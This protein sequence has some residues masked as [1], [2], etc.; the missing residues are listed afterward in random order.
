[1]SFESLFALRYLRAKKAD[2]FISIITWLSLVGIMLGVAT[3]IIVM[4]VMNGFR[5]EMMA[6]IMGLNGH[7]IVYPRPGE[8]NI[9]NYATISEQIKA[10]L[11]S[12]LPFAPIPVIDEQVMISANGASAGIVLRG[13]APYDMENLAPLANGIVESSKISEIR[14]VILG[15]T[16]ANR[17]NVMMGDEVSITSANG[18]QTAFGTVPRIKAFDVGATFKSGMSIYD[19]TF[20][21]IDFETAADF[22]DMAGA[23]NIE[24]FINSP[25]DAPRAAAKLRKA[26]PGYRIYT[27]QDQNSS[28]VS[29]LNVERNVMFIILTLIIIVASF[30]IISSLVMLV[31]DK[32]RDIAVLRTL[33]AT[34][35]SITRIFIISGGIIG[36]GGTILGL[37]LGLLISFNIEWVRQLFQVLTGTPLFPEEVYFLSEMPSKVQFSEVFAVA[38]MSLLISFIATIYP[39]R[40]AAKVAPAKVLRYE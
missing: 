8:T 10:T 11:K 12:D 32:S 9:K 1:M 39:A 15:I 25:D 18:N 2:G 6:K 38:A 22:L 3:L 13:I 40:K 24:I 19:T 36:F 30:N 28:F 14:G 27:W 16:L 5:E 17:L 21:F 31:S 29:A 4:S 26:L 34:K 20:G 33:G 35:K 23:S 7:I 37:I